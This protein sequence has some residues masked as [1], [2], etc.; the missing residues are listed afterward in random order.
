MHD[1]GELKNVIPVAL[2]REQAEV[3]ISLVSMELYAAG[4]LLHLHLRLQGDREFPLGKFRGP[5]GPEAAIRVADQIG[6]YSRSNYMMAGGSR[7]EWRFSYV[8]TPALRPSASWLRVDIGEIAMTLVTSSGD[9]YRER[10]RGPW[11]FDVSLPPDVG[12][13][14]LT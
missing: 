6:E 10:W 1:L 11:I 14:S 3:K 5:Q 2:T 4:M 8:L 13:T 9:D 7:K 12:P